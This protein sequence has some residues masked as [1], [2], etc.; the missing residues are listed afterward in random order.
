MRKKAVVFIS[1]MIIMIV[2][3]ASDSLR[4]IFAVMFR[5]HFELSAFQISLIITVSYLGNLI[6]LFFGGAFLDRYHKK[7]ALLAVISIWICGAAL[8]ILTDSYVLLLIGM[9]FCMGASTL[10]NTT[11]NI[12][13]PAVFAASPGIIVNIL[14]FLQGVGTSTSQN[15]GGKLPERYASW[16][17]MNLFL[18]VL[19]VVGLIFL[20]LADIPEVR[21]EDRKKVSYQDILV[22]PIFWSL[23][24]IFGFYFIA[25]HGILNWLLLYGMNELAL[26]SGQASKYL[27]LFF[28]GITLGRLV[29]APVVQKLG[30]KKSIT[31]F[32]GVGT[33]GYIT[34]IL[35]GKPGIILLSL[36]GL[37]ISILYPTLVLMIRLFYEED[38]IATAT[39]AVISLATLFDIAFNM[40][41]G[42]LVDIYGLQ[43]SIMILPISM[44]AFYISYMIFVGCKK[45]EVI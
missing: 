7:K 24:L 37:G 32:G 31:V 21:Q 16:Q 22:A 28:G 5:E 45:K 3:G 25:E 34:G 23:T 11:I 10:I 40:A 29:F 17:G 38:R 30:V 8:F 12:L 43:L 20:L 35:A 6:F 41:F 14:F 9:F 4:G 2:M 19:A 44:A 42:K 26:S 33:V 36:S 13:V 18:A 1:F 15:L 27:S 39:G